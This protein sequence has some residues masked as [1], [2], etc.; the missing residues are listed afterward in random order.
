MGKFVCGKQNHLLGKIAGGKS[1]P[2]W[3]CRTHHNQ[4]KNERGVLRSLFGT[5]VH[6]FN[7][8]LQST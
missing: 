7:I 5:D 8:L 2:A 3:M 1:A 4:H 6:H